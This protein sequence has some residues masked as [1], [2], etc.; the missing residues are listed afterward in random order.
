MKVPDN[1]KV[2]D[3]VKVDIIPETADVYLGP[4]YYD[5]PITMILTKNADGS[6][7]STD[8]SNYPDATIVPHIA[9]GQNSA[10]IPQDQVKDG[11]NVVVQTIDTARHKSA[12]VT[13]QAGKDTEVPNEAGGVSPNNIGSS[14]DDFA[15]FKQIVG[16]LNMGAG[17]DIL[18]ARSTERPF[19]LN[20][21][22]A[23]IDMGSGDDIVRTSG[24]IQNYLDERDISIDGGDD[25]DTFEF[26]NRD[27]K[28]IITTISALS[29]FEKIDITGTLNNTVNIQKE[30]VER[31]HNA[32]P[33]VDDSGESHKNVLIID[34]NAGDKVN[35]N[36]IS[37]VA[38]SQVTYENKTYH[39]YHT[40]S[41][42][43]WVESDI[44]VV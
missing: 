39:V 42:E 21:F 20:T 18:E 3:T 10:T 17:N 5:R 9:A 44:A 19:Y 25:F 32:K 24:T 41:N 30:D 40:G 38:S 27:G 23:N 4:E 28:A 1:A 14:G 33:T 15:S 43:L 6:W 7:T 22:D 29:N 11:S 12:E 34:G 2:G 26:V 31:N 37:N 36:D 8:T 13:A 16:T 35:L